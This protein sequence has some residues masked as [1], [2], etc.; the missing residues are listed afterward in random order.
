MNIYVVD[1]N[2]ENIKK[3]AGS[4]GIEPTHEQAEVTAEI[5]LL[6]QEAYEE[7]KVEGVKEVSLYNIHMMSDEQW[8]ELAKEK[9]V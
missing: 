8:N 2:A 3:L 1:C 6:L 5:L 4:V 9:V 7:G